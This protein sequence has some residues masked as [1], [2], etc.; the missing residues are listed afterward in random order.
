[1]HATAATAEAPRLAPRASGNS[2]FRLTERELKQY[3]LARAILTA[4]EN[5]EAKMDRMCF[6]LEVSQEIERRSAKTHGGIFIPYQL[7][8]GNRAGLDSKTATTG[9]EVKF[10]EPGTFIEFLYN[11]MRVKELGG[12]R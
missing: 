9:Q 5:M 8:L 1:M 3:S 10:T 7:G 6:E 4:S 2:R 11:R 12:I